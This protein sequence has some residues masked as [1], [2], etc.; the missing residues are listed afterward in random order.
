[1]NTA[2]A[3]SLRG[4]PSLASAFLASPPVSRV[5]YAQA[6]T[7]FV[8]SAFTAF[9]S[10]APTTSFVHMAALNPISNSHSNGDSMPNGQSGSNGPQNGFSSSGMNGAAVNNDSN[11]AD[12]IVKTAGEMPNAVCEWIHSTNVLNTNGGFFL[13]LVD[14]N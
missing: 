12:S 7:S 1:M 13:N 3:R 9:A 8:A 11:L 14:D 10:S 4:H 5:L 2:F 6:S